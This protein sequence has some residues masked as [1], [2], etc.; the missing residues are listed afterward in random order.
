MIGIDVSHWQETIDWACAAPNIGFAILKCSQGTTIA[1][2]YYARNKAECLINGVAHGAYHWLEPDIDGQA[3]ANYFY[4]K[5]ND[6]DMA[7][8]VLDV[9][10]AGA[11]LMINLEK[12]VKRLRELTGHQPIIYTSAGFWNYNT[13]TTPDWAAACPLWVANYTTAAAPLMPRGWTS[14]RIWQYT[15]RGTVPGIAGGVDCNRFNGTDA[16]ALAFFGNGDEFAQPIVSS[17]VKTLVAV[18]IRSAPI[19]S[20]TTLLGYSYAGKVWEVMARVKD[21][22]GR[23]WCQVGPAAF[24]AGWLTVPV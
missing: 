20:T 4:E 21:A 8:W 11:G 14:W 18:N 17:R 9:E 7:V 10:E 24:I 2:F 1:D 6:P 16:E 23:E 22:D 15:D 12:A 19:V 3:Q 5:G 13:L